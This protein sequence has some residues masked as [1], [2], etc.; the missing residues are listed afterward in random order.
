LVFSHMYLD[1][2]RLAYIC[3]DAWNCWNWT[4]HSRRNGEDW[5]FWWETRFIHLNEN[6]NNI[7]GE[8]GKVEESMR[9]MAAI[10]ALKG[11][12]ADKEVRL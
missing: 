12:K 9:E 2:L 3:S 10:E 4:C 11:E 5:N 7:A 6:W 1:S 8:Q